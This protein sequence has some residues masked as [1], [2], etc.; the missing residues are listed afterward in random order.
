VISVA[1]ALGME[2]TASK[3]TLEIAMKKVAGA[4]AIAASS[5]ACS[6]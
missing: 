1:L 6:L 3:D 4:F 2:V 5:T